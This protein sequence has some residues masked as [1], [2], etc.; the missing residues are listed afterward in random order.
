MLLH[1]TPSER[2]VLQL[3]AAGGPTPDIAARLRISEGEVEGCLM[4]LYTRF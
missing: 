1:I 4:S 2:V 3:L